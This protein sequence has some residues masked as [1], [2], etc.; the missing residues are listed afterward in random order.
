VPAAAWEEEEGVQGLVSSSQPNN[1]PQTTDQ[2][3]NS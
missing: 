3:T 1:A 2:K